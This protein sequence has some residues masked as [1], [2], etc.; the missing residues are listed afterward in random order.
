MKGLIIKDPWIDLILDGI[1]TWEI[2]GSNTKHRGRFELIKSGT[3]MIY[4][5]VNLVDTFRMSIDDYELNRDRHQIQTDGYAGF[6]HYNTPWVWEMENPKLYPKPIPY[7]HPQGAV[8][9]VNL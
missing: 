8:I 9:W 5:S 7:K 2:R 3:G 1:K 4:G 6:V